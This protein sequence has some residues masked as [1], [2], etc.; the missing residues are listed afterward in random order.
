MHALGVWIFAI[1]TW[2]RSLYRK[3]RRRYGIALAG[4]FMTIIFFIAGWICQ[5]SMRID[6]TKSTRMHVTFIA[7]SNRLNINFSYAK[8]IMDWER[9]RK[10]AVSETV[11]NERCGSSVQSMRQV[12]IFT[13]WIGR[14]IRHSKHRCTDNLLNTT[15]NCVEMKCESEPSQKRRKKYTETEKL[16]MRNVVPAKKFSTEN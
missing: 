13:G 9:E 15:D 16:M 3:M 1:I 14:Y 7:Y 10:S 11:G 6:W 4:D 2:T 5:D 12:E 8:E